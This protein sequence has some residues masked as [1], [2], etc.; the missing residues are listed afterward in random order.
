[1][2][3]GKMAAKKNIHTDMLH[4]YIKTDKRSLMVFYI[5][6]YSSHEM[7]VIDKL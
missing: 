5:L 6:I 1:M 3:E 4:I 7:S 2:E